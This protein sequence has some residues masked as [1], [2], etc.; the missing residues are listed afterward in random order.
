MLLPCLE[1]DVTKRAIAI[2]GRLLRAAMEVHVLA[3]KRASRETAL[4]LSGVASTTAWYE[5]LQASC[6]L[7]LCIPNAVRLWLCPKGFGWSGEVF[8][9][10]LSDLEEAA[11]AA[12]ARCRGYVDLTDVTTTP[13][14]I[15]FR[16]TRV[17][18]A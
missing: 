17:W 11:K 18:P 6:I 5:E 1:V 7:D 14:G 15:T 12:K 13:L 9:V 3:D 4:I 10:E 16:L 2:P 8:A